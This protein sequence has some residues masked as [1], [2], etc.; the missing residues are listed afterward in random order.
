MRLESKNVCVHVLQNYFEKYEFENIIFSHLLK[1]INKSYNRHNSFLG[2]YITH[3][4]PSFYWICYILM[5]IEVIF[6]L[7]SYSS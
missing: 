3:V 1:V 5:E 7:F 2:I 4:S 6:S